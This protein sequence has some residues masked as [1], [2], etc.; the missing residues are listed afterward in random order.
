MKIKFENCEVEL[1]KLQKGT[2]V[3]KEGA[4]CH[5]KLIGNV[6]ERN[7]VGRVVDILTEGLTDQLLFGQ[8]HVSND[9]T[10]IAPH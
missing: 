8:H 1:W 10:W 9:L 7:N 3:M 4:A 2:V 6:W 5:I